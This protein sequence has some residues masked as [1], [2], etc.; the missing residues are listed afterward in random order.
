ML[1]MESLTTSVFERFGGT[2]PMARA[3]NTNHG[4]VGS[5]KKTRKIPAKWQS[6]VLE[7]AQ[8]LNLGITAEDIVYP[9]PEDRPVA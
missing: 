8:Q 1:V 9:F 7:R 6:I 4:T 5:W 3:L 2:R